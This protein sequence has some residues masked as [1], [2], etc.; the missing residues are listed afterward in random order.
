MY[1]EAAA[2]GMLL[3]A[4]DTSADTAIAV[5]EADGWIYNKDGEAYTEG[6]RYKKIP[7]EYPT[8]TISTTSPSTALM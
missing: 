6:V 5:L 1:K 8:R 7:A 2:N 3:N 4:Y